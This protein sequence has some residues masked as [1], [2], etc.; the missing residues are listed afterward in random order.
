MPYE[1]DL[2]KISMIAKLFFVKAL[3]IIRPETAYLNYIA[4]S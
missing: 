2:V 4:R 1:A 3:T